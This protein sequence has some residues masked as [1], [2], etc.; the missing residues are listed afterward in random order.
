MDQQGAVEYVLA[1]AREHRQADVDL[2]LERDE[3]L[4]LRVFAGQVEQ[5]DQAT[6][7]GLGIRV[8]HEGRTGLAFTERLGEDALEKT[9]RAAEDNARLNDPAEVVMPAAP[10]DVPDAQA[11]DL[12]HPELET[13]TVAELGAFGL[14]IEATARQADPR[15]TAVSRL[16]V[17]RSTT[18]YRV[19]STH[20]VRYHQRHNSVGAYCQV[21]LEAQDCRKSGAYLWTQRRW[22]PTQAQHIGTMADNKAAALLHAGP[23][24]GG[25][26]PVVFDEFCAPQ[27]LALYFGC[28]SAEAVQKGQSRL[29]GK[30]GESIAAEAIDLTDEPHRVGAVGSRYVDAEGIPTR[31]LPLIEQGRL[32]NFLYHIDSARREGRESTGHAGRSYDGGVV[33]SSHNLVLPTGDYTLED[34]IGLPER[35]LLVTE[36]EGAAGCNPLSGDISIG[37]QGFWVDHGQRLQP[38]DSV[39]IA[40]NF[41]DLL[42]SIRA[43]GNTYQ[44]NLT[45]MFIPPVL[46]EGLTVSS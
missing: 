30:L 25:P 21:L 37:V 42:T 16:M 6:A 46:V 7:L 32:V 23:I 24:P 15:L 31:Q 14:E 43:R 35:C 2:L 27:L 12:F 19:V 5:V 38:V 11:L 40:G 36:L 4:S 28:F 18:E 26:V 13:L 17:S 1:L 44:P 41:F 34:L 3:K 39:T 20:G 29:R 10:E 8:V 22:D 45:R 9:F 33:T